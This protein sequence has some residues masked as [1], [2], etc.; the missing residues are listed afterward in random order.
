[1][2]NNQKGLAHI[3]LLILLLAGIAGGVFLV[4]KSG[5]QIFKPKAT[6][7]SFEFINGECVQDKDGSKVLTCAGPVQFKLISPLESEQ[8][9][10]AGFEVVKTAYA[11]TGGGKGFYCG[12]SLE[13][14]L[15]I[16]HQK[17]SVFLDFICDWGL[18]GA[19]WED[20]PERCE[21]GL[22]CEYITEGIFDSG[23]RCVPEGEDSTFIPVAPIAPR[24]EQPALPTSPPAREPAPRSSSPATPTPRRATPIP[25]IPAAAQP[26]A[27]PKPTAT[28]QPTE[29]VRLSP[30]PT[31]IPQGTGATPT[32]TTAATQNPTSTP[33][34]T[35]RLT[36]LY[37]FAEDPSEWEN[38]DAD[39]LPYTAGGVIVTHTFSKVTPGQPNFIFAQFKDNQRSI[40][41]AK[42]Y[43]ARIYFVSEIS[44][45]PTLASKSVQTPTSVP[46]SSPTSTP[47]PI[48]IPKSTAV[49]TASLVSCKVPEP[50][51]DCTTP[52]VEK[53]NITILADADNCTNDQL[54]STFSKDQLLL[55]GNERLMKLSNE[56]LLCFIPKSRIVTFPSWRLE[57]FSNDHLLLIGDASGDCKQ[58]LLNFSCNRIISLP[59]RYQ[60]LTSC[61][62]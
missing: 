24:T 35:A 12:P 45:T 38:D 36:T 5:Y 59:P 29:V 30:T 50:Y 20:V 49:P 31:P 15:F 37:R 28:P 43:P 47:M 27:V 41:N 44:A 32:P 53:C 54:L 17:C 25:T 18:F 39:W 13:D 23:A 51:V 1:M 6:S 57:S 61:G 55:L 58:F 14:R 4:S 42:P 46:K 60:A 40:I 48:S 3:F 26:T 62:R 19:E 56:Q 22:E 52:E 11:K 16:Y 8:T 21:V 9:S 33:A 10:D 2:F 34:E 7:E